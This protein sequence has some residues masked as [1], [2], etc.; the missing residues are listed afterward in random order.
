MK[1]RKIPRFKVY[2]PRGDGATSVDGH[3]YAATRSF[4]LLAELDSRISSLSEESNSFSRDITIPANRG[5]S[6][7]IKSGAALA[8]SSGDEIDDLKCLINLTP[9]IY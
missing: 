6:Y 9:D 3:E 5:R 8:F 2:D 7:G 1:R 4:P